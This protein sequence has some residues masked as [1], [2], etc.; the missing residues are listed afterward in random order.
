MKT[1][2]QHLKHITE[3]AHHSSSSVVTTED[4]SDDDIEDMSPEEA[5]ELV[6]QKFAPTELPQFN[7]LNKTPDFDFR[8]GIV[9]KISAAYGG[10]VEP[11]DETQNEPELGTFRMGKPVEPYDREAEFLAAFN[12]DKKL[13]QLEPG[14]FRTDDGRIFRFVTDPAKPT[15]QWVKP[16][17]QWIPSSA[18]D[19]IASWQ[20]NNPGKHDSAL[21]KMRFDRATNSL[22]PVDAPPALDQSPKSK[23]KLDRG[24]GSVA[25]DEPE[26]TD[27]AVNQTTWRDIYRLNKKTI[28][29][30]PGLIKP[31]QVLK[32]PNDAPDY[33]VQKGDSLVKIA[34]MGT[35][36][37]PR[38]PHTPTP[39]PAA[40]TK[41]KTQ[42]EPIKKTTSIPG[43]IQPRVTANTGLHFRPNDGF[44]LDKGEEI[45]T[46][47]ILRAEKQAKA[48]IAAYEKK[49]RDR[50]L[51][52]AA[53]RTMKESGL[54]LI[55]HLRDYI[56][57]VE[58]APA[59]TPNQTMDPQQAAAAPATGTA[60]KLVTPTADQLK[61]QYKD[62][63][64]VGQG[65]GSQG[66]SPEAEQQDKQKSDQ[67]IEF[68]TKAVQAHKAA[69]RTVRADLAQK[70]L[71]SLTAY[72]QK[73]G[74]GTNYTG[75]YDPDAIGTLDN[76]YPFARLVD[77][78]RGQTGPAYTGTDA[79]P[80]RPNESGWEYIA[81]A[82]A[83]PAGQ[84][85]FLAGDVAPRLLHSLNP[86][87]DDPAITDQV[88]KTLPDYNQVAAGNIGEASELDRILT[89]ARHPR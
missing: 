76:R 65:I 28:G 82:L 44:M 4:V 19:S 16:D 24:A 77:A 46:P 37:R 70:Q 13:P 88:R 31:G 27:T 73:A 36:A 64:S 22:V 3:T 17:D 59:F 2:R 72:A 29:S 60:P 52:Q 39:S 10:D 48:D 69:G 63:S 32:M 35:A 71:N 1:F 11:G 61:A 45:I 6:R 21:P 85:L 15:G 34:S 68:Y 43:N 25:P 56:V 89:I 87:A 18:A 47:A 38:F 57:E 5:E 81:K 51:K 20:A 7:R 54:G 78:V 9:D 86:W 79:D 62:V 40:P 8:K 50:E 53:K 49:Q 42:T 66:K 74:P 30:D 84:T 58:T 23:F 14:E 67:A 80:N 26:D 55:K 12:A 41:T 33:T 83:M 75:Q